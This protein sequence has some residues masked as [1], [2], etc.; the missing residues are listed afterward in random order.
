M[1]IACRKNKMANSLYSAQV[2]RGWEEGMDCWSAE[3]MSLK[4]VTKD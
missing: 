4:E 3:L 1:A 2:V